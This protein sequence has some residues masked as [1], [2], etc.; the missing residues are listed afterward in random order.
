M[1]RPCEYPPGCEPYQDWVT[2]DNFYYV[3]SSMLNNPNVR[4]ASKAIVV[5]SE[6]FSGTC[7]DFFIKIKQ[8]FSINDFSTLLNQYSLTY[9]DASGDF[10][11]GIYKISTT[12]EDSRWCIERANIFFESGKCDFSHPNFYD[13]T[14]LRTNDPYWPDQWNLLNTGQYG[15]IPGAD[16][17]IL[18]AWPISKG[19]NVKVAVIDEGVQ[20]DHRDLQANLLPGLDVTGFNTNGGIVGFYDEIHGSSMAGIIGAI[21]DNGLDIAG[22]APLCK[23]IPI[24]A[25]NDGIFNH[26]GIARAFI[27]AYQQGADVINC[28]W[29]FPLGSDIV[30]NA[31][32]DAS[33]LGR[34]GKGCIIVAAVD[35]N[36]NT[37]FEFPENIQSVIAVGAMTPCNER[38]KPIIT[39]DPSYPYAWQ[40][41]SNYG[42]KLSVVAPGSRVPTIPVYAFGFGPYGF[43]T[44]TSPAAAQVSAVAALALS[45]NPNLSRT[46]VQRI[47]ELGSNR[48]GKYCYNWTSSHPNGPWNNE[49][50]YGRLNAYNAVQLARP[51]VTISNPVYDVSSQTSTQVSNN[52]GIIFNGQACLTSLPFGVNFVRRYE[53]TTTITY[54]NTP[55][56]LIICTSNGFNLANP[57]DGRRFAE[58]INITN[59]SATLRTYIY[60]GYNSIG[61]ELGWIPTSPSNIKF[62]YSIVSSPTPVNYELQRPIND[63]TNLNLLTNIPFKLDFSDDIRI[64]DIPIEL[65]TTTV[66]PN[67][68][69]SVLTI[70]LISEIDKAENIEIINTLGI[71]HTRI[72]PKRIT[73]GINTIEVDVSSFPK[74]VYILKMGSQSHKFVKL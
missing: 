2:F 62:T 47:L 23:I 31:I 63:N 45:V 7:E 18:N 57:N 15:G 69:L 8:G 38:K 30:I 52:L 44:G 29:G 40:W 60:Y 36:N 6:N 33:T 51:G 49:M 9:L 5:S 10:G 55:N 17:R 74:G 22:V 27:W 19:N 65:N 12:R 70:K 58:A 1:Q 54:P 24:K 20:L 11:P 14:R 28:S 71:K 64:N 59:T 34:N 50:G 35:N 3:L 43:S 37:T 66:S 73:K 42:D 13:F 41:G 25:F 48:V 26:A 61:Q 46:E 16:I 4:S 72:V 32:N 21:A 68:V 53:V 67:P 39:C 56:P